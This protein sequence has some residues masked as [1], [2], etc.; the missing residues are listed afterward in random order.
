MR[1]RASAPRTGVYVI[2]ARNVGRTG[3]AGR[4]RAQVDFFADAASTQEY[5]QH[6]GVKI[7]LN[8][9][10]R[11]DRLNMSNL[12]KLDLLYNIYLSL[13]QHIIQG[14]KGVQKKHE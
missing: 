3:R 9:F 1:M 14:V 6:V 7:D 12:Y 5:F 8:V 2:C 10:T 13:F 4:S 11:L